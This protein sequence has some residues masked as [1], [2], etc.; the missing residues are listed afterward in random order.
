MPFIKHLFL[1]LEANNYRPR[2]LEWDYFSFLVLFMIGIKIFSVASLQTYLGA[3]IFNSLT[4]ED[5]YVLTNDIRKENKVSVLRPNLK[6]E[7]AAKM[8]LEDMLQNNYFSHV[9][10]AGTTPWIWIGKANYDYLIAGENLAM[11]F[12]S[13]DET[14]KAWLNS[15]THRRNI[16]LP[17][18]KDIGIA[19]GSGVINGQKTMVVVEMFGKPRV[20]RAAPVVRTTAVKRTPP[21]PALTPVRTPTPTP[22]PRPVSSLIPLT[23]VKSEVSLADSEKQ[24]RA[25]AE[26]YSYSLFLEKLMAIIFVV[27]L[28]IMILKIFVNVNIQVPE[29]ILRAAIL[30]L[31]SGTF[32]NFD[33]LRI[34]SLLQGK[35]ILP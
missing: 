22:T 23:Q 28:G 30:V 7:F 1:P 5:L 33:D 29:L 6:L 14:M 27:T 2:I 4:R 20:A 35:V 32:I 10:P 18:F 8:K 13:S 21:A 15:E 26:A 24:D 34:L 16:L 11:N 19:V 9:S 31:I 17:D 3:D 25:G 12:F